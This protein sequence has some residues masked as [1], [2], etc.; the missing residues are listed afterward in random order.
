VTKPKVSFFNFV[1]AP[2]NIISAGF[3]T[4]L[5][6]L[7]TSIFYCITCKDEDGGMS[8]FQHIA[9]NGQKPKT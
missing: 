1:N 6:N 4:T 9:F 2:K 8:G 3:E 5:L 7:C